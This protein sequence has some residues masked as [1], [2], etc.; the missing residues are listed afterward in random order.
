MRESEGGDGKFSGKCIDTGKRVLR[1][2]FTRYDYDYDGDETTKKM[3][4]GLDTRSQLTT[5]L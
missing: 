4:D 3:G 2:W 5:C 1:T